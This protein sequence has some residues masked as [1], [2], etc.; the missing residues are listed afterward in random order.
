VTI[1]EEDDPL[2]VP[3]LNV[4][5]GSVLVLLPPVT[6]TLLLTPPTPPPL[7]VPPGDAN[8][9]PPITMGE[10]EKIPLGTPLVK[11]QPG[12]SGP[13]KPPGLN[14]PP[15][16]PGDICPPT[17]PGLITPPT[18]GTFA[19]GGAPWT[20]TATDAIKITNA[21]LK[22]VFIYILNFVPFAIY[23]IGDYT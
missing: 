14:V 22:R 20:P 13:R 2:T 7:N 16:A 9:P 3:L 8:A 19:T 12:A 23:A 18:G 4:P 1:T 21:L 17:G 6:M 11:P 10:G 15:T 5:P